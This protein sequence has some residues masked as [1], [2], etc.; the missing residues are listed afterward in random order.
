[1][2][3]LIVSS[4]EKEEEKKKASTNMLKD[5][6][7]DPNN[8]PK[9]DRWLPLLLGI[10]GAYLFFNQKTPMQEVSFQEFLND[11]LI[12]RRVAKVDIVK[13]QMT[14]SETINH[15]AECTL[16]DGSKVYVVLYSAQQFLSKL[17]YVQK[18]M[19]ID[20]SQ[21]IPVSFTKSGDD[22]SG[23]S[24]VTTMI[25]GAAFVAILY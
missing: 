23:S 12:T 15:R 5:F 11:Y 4:I 14:K 21:W 6:F 19:K 16:H 1:M 24:P 13:D 17:E 7:F 18:E 20:M 25:I 9:P 3:D 2:S 10:G 8:D 22:I